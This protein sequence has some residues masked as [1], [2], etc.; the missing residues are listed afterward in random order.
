MCHSISTT[1]YKKY[2]SH[3]H[4]SIFVKLEYL[5]TKTAIHYSL[6]SVNIWKSYGK[7]KGVT[8]ENS[9]DS[10]EKYHWL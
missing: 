7:N 6:K 2:L 8:L 5:L 10:V 3:K 4:K 9:S 1:L